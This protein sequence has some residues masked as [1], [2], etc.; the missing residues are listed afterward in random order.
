MEFAERRIA[1]IPTASKVGLDQPYLGPS[2]LVAKR[3]TYYMEFL[4][5]FVSRKAIFLLVLSLSF[6]AL[7][8]YNLLPFLANKLK[9]KIFHYIHY[10]AE[11]CNELAGPIPAS[12]RPST[13]FLWKKCHSGGEL[14]ATLCPI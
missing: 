5:I 12:L 9:S 8:F 2:L 4:I 10:Y 3:L 14:L 11:A 13:Q 6:K 1:N 7:I